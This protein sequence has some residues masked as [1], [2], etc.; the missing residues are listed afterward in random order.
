MSA[1][2][3][4]WLQLRHQPVRLAVA[5]AGVA[6]AV[7][8]MLMQL[9]FM[10]ALFRS[11]VAFHR[12]LDGEIVLVHPHYTALGSPTVFPR[13]RL[14]QALGVPGVAGVT[15]LYTALA[16][17]KNPWTGET[18]DAFLVG[19]D[20]AA[21]ALRIPGVLAA[22]ALLQL[23][24]VVLFDTHSRPQFGPVAA[25]LAGQSA[26]LLETEIAGRRIAVRG[27]FALG[28]AIGL[29]ATVVTSDLNFRRILPGRD[30][31]AVGIGLVRLAPGVD[32][33]GVRDALVRALPSDVAVLTRDEF[34]DRELIFW[35]TVSP[36]GF[37]F[38][39]GVAMGLVVGTIIVY[40]IL[41][42]DIAD[43]EREYATL[44]AM[45]Y[46]HGYLAATVATEATILA[47]VGAL[48]GIAVS[49]WLYGVAASATSLPMTL[50]PARSLHVLG[51][52]LAMCW[53]SGLIATRKLRTADPAEIL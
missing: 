5:V 14:Y 35:R 12:T 32:P 52:G 19:I 40:Q 39:F 27:L 37:V 21:G 20:P 43:H 2:R 7:I 44:K 53:T 11:A 47:V 33:P 48:P 31:A 30:E 18:R 26:P 51:L 6:F 24:D 3:L 23:Q 46:G 49:W 25:V 15:G 22:R 41:F 16:R 9:G 38:T 8:L 42:A 4:A 10:D 28:T 17:W 36:I 1:L 45:G 50:G 34:V 29:E 13:R